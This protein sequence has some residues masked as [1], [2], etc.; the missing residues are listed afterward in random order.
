MSNDLVDAMANMRE[1]EAMDL[2]KKMLDNG[3]D[4]LKILELCREALE[5]VGK[6]FE[7]GKYFLPELIMAGEML[8]EISTIAKPYI[9]QETNEKA[10]GKPDT[11]TLMKKV[12]KS[13]KKTKKKKIH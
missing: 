7:E 10:E 13:R 1:A 2:A 12:N 3:Q 11:R 5:I 6:R 4:P 8:K 9:K